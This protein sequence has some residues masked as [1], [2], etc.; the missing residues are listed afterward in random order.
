MNKLIRYV[1]SADLRKGYDG[2]SA[3]VNLRN[4]KKGEFVAFVN[5]KLDKVKLCTC[6]DLVAYLRLPKGQRINPDVIQHLPE[7]FD[8]SSINYG[9]AVEKSL[10]KSFPKW[11]DKELT[12]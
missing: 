11:F 4:L 1:P 5:S 12:S 2:L 7:A 6:N 10:R 3:E 8:G 9:K